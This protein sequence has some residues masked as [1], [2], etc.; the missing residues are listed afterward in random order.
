MHFN[1]FWAQ[2]DGLLAGFLCFAVTPLFSKKFS[3][4][5]I[6]LETLRMLFGSLM[7]DLGCRGDISN[8]VL[9]MGEIDKG[10]VRWSVG[11]EGALEIIKGNSIITRVVARHAF[12]QE[13][14]SWFFHYRVH[15]YVAIQIHV[16]NSSSL[17]LP[18]LQ[19]RPDS[20]KSMISR[21]VETEET[22]RFLL[23]A[24]KHVGFEN[25]RFMK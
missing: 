20:R 23:S 11:L 6:S 8:R 15:E 1:G 25:L 9:R 22:G 5:C 13:P 16:A 21:L 7:Q 14:I 10:A 12:F 4:V 19:C 2:T 17:R 24:I 3:E 18:L